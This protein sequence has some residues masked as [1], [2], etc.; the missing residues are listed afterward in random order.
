M[1][2]EKSHLIVSCKEPTTAMAD[3][4]SIEYNT[5]EIILG[6]KLDKVLKF[7]EQVN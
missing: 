5:T 3:G 7:K 4:L 6:I 2:S 1:N